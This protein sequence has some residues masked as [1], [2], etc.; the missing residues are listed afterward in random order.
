[1][2]LIDCRR[3]GR[4]ERHRLPQVEITRA[5][6]QEGIESRPVDVL[7]EEYE[8]A[9][10]RRA[11][12]DQRADM[13]P[14]GIRPGPDGVRDRDFVIDERGRAIGCDHACDERVVIVVNEKRDAV[15]LGRKLAHNAIAADL[16]KGLDGR[17]T[18]GGHRL[19]VARP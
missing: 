4:Q 10:G 2:P 15:G 18:F 11:E 5:L 6:V 1:M 16:A 19:S 14:E 13:D 8:A 17:S 12:I 3:E 9:V 7:T